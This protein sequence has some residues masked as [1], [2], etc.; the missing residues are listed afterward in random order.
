MKKSIF[1]QSGR[2]SFRDLNW[3]CAYVRPADILKQEEK[4]QKK[5]QKL[6]D[7][8]KT[9]SVEERDGVLCLSVKEGTGKITDCGYDQIAVC[10]TKIPAGYD[11]TLRA[12]LTVRQFLTG[13]M[14]TYQEGFGLF[15]RDTVDMDLASGQRGAAGTLAVP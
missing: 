13:G 1:D 12:K 8:P 6:P 3:Q 4:E 5:G 11:V 14:P 2:Y 10:C 7:L 9:V 15:F